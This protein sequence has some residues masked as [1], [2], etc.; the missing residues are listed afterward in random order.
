MNQAWTLGYGDMLKM[1]KIKKI[2]QKI[3]NIITFYK[4]PKPTNWVWFHINELTKND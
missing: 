1:N 3:I 4:E 2:I